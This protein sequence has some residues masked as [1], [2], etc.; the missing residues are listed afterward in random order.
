M[1]FDVGARLQGVG[2]MQKDK[3]IVLAAFFLIVGAILASQFLPSVEG[4]APSAPRAAPSGP[5][6]R[7][8]QTGVYR[9]ISLQLHSPYRSHPYEQYIREIAET[10]ANTVCLVVHGFQDNASSSSIFIDLRKSPSPRRV[11][12]LIDFAH[13]R[14]LRVVLM[15][16]VLLE[17]PRGDEWRGK[18]SP[19]SWDDWWEE[20]E[21]YLL[22]YVWIA[23]AAGAE[24]FMIGSE[25]ISTEK[26]TDRWRKLIS[27]LRESYQGLLSYSANWDH[28]R[29]P[30]WWGDLDIIGMTTYYDLTGGKEPTLERLLEAWKPIR[31]EI[32]DWQSR[33][34]RPILFTE[35]GW[36][37]QETCAQYPWNYYAS[38]DKPDPQA[39]K[40]CFEAFFRT[41]SGQDQVAGF[42]VWEWRN[43]PQQKI[44]PDDTSYTPCGK[45][46]M[47]VIRKYFLAPPALTTKPSRP[48]GGPVSAAK[49]N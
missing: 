46:A 32:L 22:H 45:P 15:P 4:P 8:R 30:Q 38:V 28:Y 44:G 49:P 23:E 35:V 26:Q 40:N 29:V 2:I 7:P 12:E 47:E 31:E 24:V 5:P 1:A 27:R 3:L 14:G 6:A 36:P 39:Q 41:W 19:H 9:G 42:L 25:L 37:N 43:F 33:I 18:I 10:G 16:I 21:E 34:G 13:G 48:A 17:R 20:Y 11:K